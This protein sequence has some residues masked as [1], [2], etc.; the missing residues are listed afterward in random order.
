MKAYANL[1]SRIV[2]NS[3]KSTETGIVQKFGAGYGEPNAL[4][5]VGRFTRN[6]LSPVVSFLVDARLGE[7]ALGKKRTVA[8]SALNRIKPIFLSN[9]VDIAKSDGS[10]EQKGLAALVGLLGSGVSV[11]SVGDNWND[12]ES[13]EMLQLKEKV[14]QEQFDEIN[15]DFNAKVK[16]EIQN[17]RKSA[18]YKALDNEKKAKKV[19]NMK[20]KVKKEIF[21]QYGFKATRKLPTRE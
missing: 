16:S 6:K 7:D 10:I 19:N 11:Y 2:T 8:Q 18:E 9:L 14:G 1:I 15:S 13:A 17:F 4:E 20:S 21:Q 12:K 5:A 3:S